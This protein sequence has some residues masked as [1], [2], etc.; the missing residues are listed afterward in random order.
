[1]DTFGGPAEQNPDG[2][3]PED[4]QMEFPANEAD[5]PRDSGGDNDDVR[6]QL[7]NRAPNV[8]RLIDSARENQALVG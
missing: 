3:A 6:R 1:M 7:S 2:Q 4:Q 5:A 8:A